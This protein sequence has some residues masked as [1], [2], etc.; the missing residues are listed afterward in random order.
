MYLRLILLFLLILTTG[1]SA[2]QVAADAQSAT[3][4][5]PPDE[6]TLETNV[7]QIILNDEHRNGVDWGAIVSDFNT[8]LLKK[9]NDP[10]WNDKKYRLSFGTVSQDDYAV[11]LDALD[12]VGQMSQFPQPPVKI[13]ASTP[14]VI[15]L[16]KQNIRVELLLS[17][18]KSGDLSLRIEPHIAVAATELWDGQKIPASVILEAETKILIA[19]NSTIVIGGLM[20]E[21]EITKM[22]KFPLLGDIPIVG[23][24]FRNQ[25]RL[26]QKT[27]TVVFLTVRTNAVEAPE[28][29][30]ST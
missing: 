8:A 28:D 20:K 15:N 23:L 30:S 29:D 25:G 16:D 6:V 26:M 12:T 13:T 21:E 19:N 11:L 2:D 1:A 10:V 22:H 27:E 18:L 7:V 24:V 9:E 5:K 4:V 14:A 3:Q 17:R